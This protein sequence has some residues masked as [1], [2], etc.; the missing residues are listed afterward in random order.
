MKKRQSEFEH[1]LRGADVFRHRVGVSLSAVGVAFLVALAVASLVTLASFFVLLSPT[2]RAV[3]GYYLPARAF[4]IVGLGNVRLLSR[5]VEIAGERLSRLTPSEVVVVLAKPFA[6]TVGF[7]GWLLWLV[8]LSSF[9][10]TPVVMMRAWTW[11]GRRLGQDEFRRAAQIVEPEKLL[12][13]FAVSAALNTRSPVSPSR[14]DLR[15]GTFW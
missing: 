15:C 14:A 10:A 9:G 2:E 4:D 7:K 13:R 12:Q 8:W 5:D 11:F 3:A 6:L 1:W